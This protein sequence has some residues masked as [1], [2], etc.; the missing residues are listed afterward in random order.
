MKSMLLADFVYQAP[1]A[2]SGEFF[3]KIDQMFGV[4]TL[5]GRHFTND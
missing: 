1:Q 5:V 3:S 4:F 2:P